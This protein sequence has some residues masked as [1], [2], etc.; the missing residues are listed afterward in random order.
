MI[1]VAE[2]S[3]EQLF[4]DTVNTRIAEV[5]AKWEG[6]TLKDVIA[7]MPPRT[8]IDVGRRTVSGIIV[9]PMQE[10]DENTVDMVR[11]SEHAQHYT[12]GQYMSA[13]LMRDFLLPNS[14]AAMF[15]NNSVT[16]EEHEMDADL[17]ND[18]SKRGLIPYAEDKV[19]ALEAMADKKL[20]SG[21]IALTGFSLGGN[22]AL[23]VAAVGSDKLDIVAINAD[24]PISAAGRNASDVRKDFMKS[25][26]PGEQLAAVAATGV[27]AFQ[28]HF[29]KRRLFI[30]DYPR[31]ALANLIRSTR[32]M[33][34][35]STGEVTELLDKASNQ[36]PNADIKL[37][38]V[39]GGTVFQPSEAIVSRYPVV[40]YTGMWRHATVNNPFAQALMAEPVIH[41]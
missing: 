29:A 7:T 41:Q 13:S 21:R 25:G 19:R 33:L 10:R 35:A 17:I 1:E 24:D 16:D 8:V 6:I 2:I 3:R 22:I 15:Q 4:N 38:V 27:L 12:A 5:K 37:G 32:G 36:Y 26:S 28:E 31:F 30:K 39:E 14:N 11:F 34:N 20:I 23:A 18:M 9:P 40:R